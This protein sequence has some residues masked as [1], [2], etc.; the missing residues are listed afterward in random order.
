MDKKVGK[1]SENQEG[2]T[3]FMMVAIGK[4]RGK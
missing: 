3:P 1:T 2:V 4:D